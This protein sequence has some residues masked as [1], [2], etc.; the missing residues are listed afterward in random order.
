MTETAWNAGFSRHAL[1]ESAAHGTTLTCGMVLSVTS[2]PTVRAV[3][4]PRVPLTSGMASA[5]GRAVGSEQP[6]A[7][8]LLPNYG[9]R[10]SDRFSR[11]VAGLRAD[12]DSAN[13]IIH[14]RDG[15]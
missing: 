4:L 7:L 6:Y 14:R 5:A 12:I 11:S 2:A 3:A 1:R 8:C 9:L 15:A 10:R 13:I